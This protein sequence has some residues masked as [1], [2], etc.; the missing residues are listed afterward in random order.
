MPDFSID[1]ELRVRVSP[2]VVLRRTTEAVGFPSKD[3]GWRNFGGL[4]QPLL[5]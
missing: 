4:I 3:G 5:K 2:P 1:P